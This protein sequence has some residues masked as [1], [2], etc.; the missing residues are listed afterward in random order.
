MFA[1]LNQNCSF[2][3]LVRNPPKSLKTCRVPLTHKGPTPRR[4][5]VPCLCGVGGVHAYPYLPTPPT[6][7]YL[8]PL[9]KV[10]R[11]SRIRWRLLPPFPSPE[12]GAVPEESRVVS[13]LY[14]GNLGA[15]PEESREVS[16][17]SGLPPVEK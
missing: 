6:H 8:L 15:I 16:G 4:Q 14:P 5:N 1:T 12:A 3:F 13:E 11:L 9:A 10:S 7:P 2:L 17:P